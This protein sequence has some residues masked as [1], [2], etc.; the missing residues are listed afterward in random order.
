[1][2]T[3]SPI[4][5][6]TSEFARNATYSQKLKSTMRVV[7]LIP[8]GPIL[9]LIRPAATTASTPLKCNRSAI[10]YEPKASTVVSVVSMR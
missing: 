1:M 7:G 4:S 8:C 5:R 6:K 9:P 10:R 2:F 3:C